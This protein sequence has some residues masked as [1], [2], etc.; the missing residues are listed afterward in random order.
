MASSARVQLDSKGIE[1]L[2]RSPEVVKDL[3]RR[4]AAV[5]AA[6]GPGMRSGAYQGRDR[7]RARVWTGSAAAKRAEAESR[8][9]TRAIDA[10]RR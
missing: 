2:L 9:L 7:A 3:E 6:A 4:A 8:A 1:Q 5:A 10:A